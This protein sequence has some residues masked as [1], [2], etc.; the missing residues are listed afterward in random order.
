MKVSKLVPKVYYSE[1]RDF[2][3]IG[4][5]FEIVFNHLKTNVDLIDASPINDEVSSMLITLAS[6]TLGFESKHEYVTK[7]LVA[8]CSSFTELLRNKGNLQSIEDAVNILI[9]TQNIKEGVYVGI[10]DD[11]NYQ[12]DI[13]VP[14]QLNDI[15]L[16][17]DLFD[18]ILPSGFTYSIKFGSYDK[19]DI[20]TTEAVTDDSVTVYSMNEEQLAQV[21]IPGEN[22][23]ENA[24]GDD[25]DR[26]MTYTG[27]VFNSN[28]GG[29]Q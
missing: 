16:L 18:Y 12:I 21:T 7:D 19:N 29:S 11:D 25:V 28:E 5:L 2:S 10:N 20:K 26:S 27:V 8:I 23:D 6:L 24:Y 17:E 22:D 14:L 13:Y 1:S 4:R 15:I 9:H 3:Y